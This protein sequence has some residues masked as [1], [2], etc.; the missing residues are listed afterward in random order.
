MLPGQQASAETSAVDTHSRVRAK[1]RLPAG[2]VRGA[3][4]VAAVA[5]M[6]PIE[7]FRLNPLNL[8]KT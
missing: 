3:V 8:S 7:Y 4:E 1:R 2:A 6:L 5:G